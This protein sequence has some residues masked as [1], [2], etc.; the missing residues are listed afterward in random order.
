MK[1][2]EDVGAIE[3]NYVYRRRAGLFTTLVK[4][5]LFPNGQQKVRRLATGQ[6]ALNPRL[7]STKLAIL[8]TH[9]TSQDLENT[10]QKKLGRMW[11]PEQR[12]VL[13][14][15]V[16][17]TWHGYSSTHSRG[18]HLTWTRASQPKLHIDRTDDLQASLLTEELLAFYNCLRRGSHIDTHTSTH[19]HT[20]T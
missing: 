2:I 4:K 16:S 9:P 3:L 19:R 13:W 17:R 12:G 1:S 20:H 14:N 18:G 8:I 15:A 7:S 6:N 10:T 5:L 11:G